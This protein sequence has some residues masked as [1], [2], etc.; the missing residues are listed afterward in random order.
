M[1]WTSVVIMRYLR[2]YNTFQMAFIFMQYSLIFSNQYQC[3][4]YVLY[5]QQLTL[6]CEDLNTEIVLGSLH[7]YV[8]VWWG[9]Q[10]DVVESAKKIS[11]RR[12]SREKMRFCGKMSNPNVEKT[13]LKITLPSKNKL[14]QKHWYIHLTVQ[15][16]SY[17]RTA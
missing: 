3:T 16:N 9:I 6:P 8:S 14:F 13:F 5:K 15:L 10:I 1:R 4:C 17:N 7:S 11:V 2:I 12:Y